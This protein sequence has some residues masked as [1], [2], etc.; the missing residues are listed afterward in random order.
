[1]YKEEDADR[2]VF[3]TGIMRAV[4]GMK[5]RSGANPLPLSVH[6]LK[7]KFLVGGPFIISLESTKY[8]QTFSY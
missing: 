5:N 7:P 3:L 8:L 6:E 4:G 2:C 1:M